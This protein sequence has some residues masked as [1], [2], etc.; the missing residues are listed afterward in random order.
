MD[1]RVARGFGAVNVSIKDKAVGPNPILRISPNGERCVW[2]EAGI[3]T[4]QLCDRNFD[5]ARCPLDAAMHH[6]ST[7][8]SMRQIHLENSR[9]FSRR[10]C[11]LLKRGDRVAVGLDFLFAAKLLGISR[12]DLPQVGTHLHPNER[13]TV[14]TA[15]GRAIPIFSPCGGSI[16]AV[17]AAVLADFSRLTARPM[18]EGWLFEFHANS[19]ELPDELLMNARE[20]APRYDDD[21]I[22]FRAS[23]QSFAGRRALG[24]TL[25]DG[26]EPTPKIFSIVTPTLYYRLLRLHF[27][28]EA[29]IED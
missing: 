1:G 17:N 25:A 5:C 26:G 28:K 18:E 23:L 10:H 14:I 19:V 16:A 20:A 12:I 6:Q 7:T 13:S 27:C 24:A 29:K 4:Y 8:S 21:D 3:L 2:M 9:L 15:M 22:D 11:W